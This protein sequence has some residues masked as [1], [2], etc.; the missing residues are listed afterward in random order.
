MERNPRRTS[1]L[2]SVNQRNEQISTLLE[3]KR[4]CMEVNSNSFGGAS[5]EI[6]SNIRKA[7]V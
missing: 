1:Y 3:G 2:G 4:C 6:Q 5:N 7:T